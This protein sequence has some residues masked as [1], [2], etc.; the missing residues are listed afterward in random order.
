MGM[1]RG[2]LWR[3]LP[4]ATHSA[5][6]ASMHQC[7]RKQEAASSL[8]F[9]LKEN[10]QG[11]R[12]KSRT[13]RMRVVYTLGPVILSGFKMSSNCSR[14]SSPSSRTSSATL[15]FVSRAFLAILVEFS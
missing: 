12:V 5:G 10:W 9:V 14:L 7:D 3:G 6:G 15:R 8:H 1:L 13:V 2:P 11:H 4:D